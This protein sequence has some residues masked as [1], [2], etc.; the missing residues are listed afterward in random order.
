MSDSNKRKAKF[1]GMPYGTAS[2]R[3]KK[4]LM[5]KFAQE[6]GYDKCYACGKPIETAEDLSV[7]HKE[8]WLERESGVEKFWDLDNIAFSHLSCN[9][10]HERTQYTLRK[11]GEPGTAWCSKC[12]EYLPEHNFQN[13]SSRWNGKNYLCKEHQA[14]Q[15]YERRVKEEKKEYERRRSIE[16]DRDI[17]QMTKEGFSTR[18]IGKTIGLS[19]VAVWRRQQ[20]MK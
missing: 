18:A 1:L 12:Q 17:A 16:L 20:L 7:E 2:A 19:N 9:I 11:Q 6:L 13:D 3:L 5:F 14:E 8:P 10:P 15:D 4:Q